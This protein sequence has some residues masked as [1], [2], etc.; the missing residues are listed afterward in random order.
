M[1]LSSAGSAH[2]SVGVPFPSVVLAVSRNDGA[3]ETATAAAGFMVGRGDGCDVVIS[4]EAVART[5]A[6]VEERGERLALVCCAPGATLRTS[7]GSTEEITLEPGVTFTIGDAEFECR[8]APASRKPAVEATDK[9]RCPY[10]GD[11]GGA[12]ELSRRSADRG[13]VRAAGDAGR[14]PLRPGRSVVAGGSAGPLPVG[15]RAGTPGRSN[16]TR[17]R[18]GT[19]S[20]SASP[21]REHRRSITSSP[22]PA[23]ASPSTPGGGPPSCAAGPTITP[24][25]AAPC[26]ART[27]GRTTRSPPNPPRKLP[28]CGSCGRRGAARP[29]ARR[30]G[31]PAAGRGR[32]LRGRGVS[33]PRRDG[34]GPPRP[35]TRTAPSPVA[36]KIRAGSEGAERFRRE[37][38]LLTKIDHPHVVRAL[39]AG[40]DGDCDYLVLEWVEGQSLK[41][42]HDRP[43]RR[44]PGR[45]PRASRRNGGRQVAEG[46]AAVHAHGVHRDVK[47]LQRAD[48]LVGRGEADGPRASPGPPRSRA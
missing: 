11:R 36:V 22:N 29:I 21:G 46:L 43:L 12:G 2:S 32:R 3:C 18:R 34:A 48:R 27:A 13:P 6:R 1:T 44:R 37:A 17:R 24:T 9:I 15:P 23:A 19:P 31:P 28:K 35:T 38:D 45:F 25:A 8:A 47:T 42:R 4:G 10:C 14:R 41:G 20:S 30:H 7:A 33:R 40:T 39:G 5:H 16:W 26:R